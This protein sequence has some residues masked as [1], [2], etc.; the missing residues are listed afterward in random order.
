MSR[1]HSDPS[2]ERRKAAY[3]A[4]TTPANSL[5]STPASTP[6]YSLATPF[7]GAASEQGHLRRQDS[8]KPS[9]FQRDAP[10]GETCFLP[11]TAC[12][13]L[14]PPLAPHRGKP[15]PPPL[16]PSVHHVYLHLHLVSHIHHHQWLHLPLRYVCTCVKCT[17]EATFVSQ[18][19]GLTHPGQQSAAQV[20]QWML[21]TWIWEPCE[22]TAA[23]LPTLRP[24]LLLGPAGPPWNPMQPPRSG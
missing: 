13:L 10:T 9:R 21:V 24:T 14:P 18:G 22:P 16:L 17:V 5:Q 1:E 7:D 23:P 19:W 20:L 2:L 11:C 12:T 3:S 15:P 4:A 6:K 8:G